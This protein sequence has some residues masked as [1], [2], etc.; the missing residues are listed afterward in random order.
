MA[1]RSR[2]LRITLAPSPAWH[3][4]LRGLVLLAALSLAA[5]LHAHE[6][7]GLLT[8]ALPGGL[9]LALAWRPARLLGP[10]APTVLSWDGQAW[11][12]P[13]GGGPLR[14][15]PMLDLGDALLLRVHGP[16]R[17]VWWALQRRHTGGDWAAF[18]AALYSARPEGVRPGPGD[19][20]P[21]PDRLP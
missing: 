9:L 2:S 1:A 19:A 20:P 13:A 12:D 14:L 10:A 18:R 21:P 17:S 7:P 11:Q 5:W 6:A 15:Q 4:A 16:G 3:A 8:L